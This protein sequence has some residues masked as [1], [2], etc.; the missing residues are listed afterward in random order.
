MPELV[1]KSVDQIIDI[2]NTHFGIICQTHPP[3]DK[4]L[5]EWASIAVNEGEITPI[6]ELQT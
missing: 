4:E 5:V 1:D 2:V 6:T 3:A